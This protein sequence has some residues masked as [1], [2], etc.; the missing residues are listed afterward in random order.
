MN[1]AYLHLIINHFPVVG[2]FMA[3]LV[4]LLGWMGKK[5]A[6]Q[7]TALILFVFVGLVSIPVYLS[8]NEAEEIVE[9]FP[10]VSHEA[11][12]AHEDSAIVTL[13]FIEVLSLA[14]L[15]GFALFGRREKLPVGFL[16]TV[17]V[18]AISVAILTA[19]TSNL[20]GK[21]HHSQEMGGT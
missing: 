11:I 13:I 20:G 9:K 6:V 18:L 16:L 5:S 3:F 17:V 8:G 10:G 4:L 12:E 2:T 14:S 1:P 21:I 7:K 19:K 15:M